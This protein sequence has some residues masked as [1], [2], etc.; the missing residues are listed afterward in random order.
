MPQFCLSGTLNSF[1]L[2]SIFIST[3]AFLIISVCI[4]LSYFKLQFQ[5]SVLTVNDIT[6]WQFNMCPLNQAINVVI[7]N[8]LICSL[9]LKE[10]SKWESCL[11]KS[12]QLNKSTPVSFQIYEN[13]IYW[14]LKPLFIIFFSVIYM[15][16]IMFVQFWGLFSANVDMW[17]FLQLIWWIIRFE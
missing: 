3:I 8:Y 17:F 2:S 9:S 14:L 10:P 12:S 15:S 11:C 16:G 1:L 5:F 4:I 6:W 7:R 13:K